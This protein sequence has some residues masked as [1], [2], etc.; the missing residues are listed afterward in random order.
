MKTGHKLTVAS[1]VLVVSILLLRVDGWFG[2]GFV[3]AFPLAILWWFELGR[4][5]RDSDAASPFRRAV[6]LLMGLPQAVFGLF[7]LI[8]G[9]S[10]IAWVLYNSFWRRDPHYTGGFLTF[11]VGPLLVLFGLWLLVDAFKRG[12]SRDGT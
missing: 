3:A 5:L 8:T 4:E 12:S 7:S 1:I 2:L 10:I 9:V 11:G 6:G